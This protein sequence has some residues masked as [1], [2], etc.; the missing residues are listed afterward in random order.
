MSEAFMK[1]IVIVIKNPPY[2]SDNGL[3]RGCCMGVTNWVTN[4]DVMLTC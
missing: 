3:A 2:Q 1:N 4:G